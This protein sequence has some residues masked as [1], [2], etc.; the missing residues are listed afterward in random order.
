MKTGRTVPFLLLA[1]M[2]SGCFQNQSTYQPFHI[3]DLSSIRESHPAIDVEL[4][5]G[6][7]YE[8]TV[9]SLRDS[10]MFAT[11]KRYPAPAGPD[12]SG[13]RFS[14]SIA[15]S[16]IAFLKSGRSSASP[17]IIA[18]SCGAAALAA[19]ILMYAL[20]ANASPEVRTSETNLNGGGGSCPFIYTKSSNGWFLDAE[21]YGAAVSRGLQRTEW[22][23]LSHAAV[24]SNNTVAIR[25]RNELDETQFIDELTVAVVD[26][27]DSVSVVADPSGV[28]HSIGQVQTPIA[29][30]SKPYPCEPARFSRSHNSVW[31]SNLYPRLTNTDSSVCDTLLFTFVKPRHA[32]SAKLVIKA[33]TT[34]T[35]FQMGRELLKLH[36]ALLPQWYRSIDRKGAA[37][38]KLMQ[39]HHSQ[40]LYVMPCNVRT[41]QGWRERADIYGASPIVPQERAYTIDLSDVPGDT[42]LIM[43]TPAIGFWAIDRIGIDFSPETPLK[44]EMCSPHSSVDTIARALTATDGRYLVLPV[45]G[46]SVDLV[47]TLPPRDRR[48]ERT[49]FIKAS[50]Y[51]NYH[52]RAQ[53]L[54][55]LSK[56]KKIYSPGYVVGMTLEQMRQK[57]MT[58]QPA[59]APTSAK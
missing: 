33:N 29:A 5:T 1:A 52:L 13:I 50:G 49:L 44:L 53:G 21:P 40:R 25:V 23:K 32:Q 16:D 24:D 58:A 55:Q 4:K 34:V 10:L 18:V 54:P 47:Y 30:Q 27:P 12:A 48:M 17:R 8:V 56:L 22:A 37:Y 2:I 38:R 59:T 51:Y 36:G 57:Q 15:L 31:E 20:Y 9:D 46:D 43:L 3:S 35:G 45:R 41:P 7:E 6:D 42:V 19:G 14:G 28:L 39:W 26:H 11:G